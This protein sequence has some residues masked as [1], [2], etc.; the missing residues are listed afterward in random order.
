VKTKRVKTIHE[1]NGIKEIVY[2]RY[3]PKDWKPIFYHVKE[4]NGKEKK[5]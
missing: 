4:T 1:T 5:D 3:N 2:H